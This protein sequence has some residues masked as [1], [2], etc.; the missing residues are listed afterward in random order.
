MAEKKGCWKKEMLHMWECEH[1]R[2]PNVLG[3]FGNLVTLKKLLYRNSP[4]RRDGSPS[5]MAKR[6][7]WEKVQ[8]GDCSDKSCQ[9]TQQASNFEW[10]LRPSFTESTQVLTWLLIRQSFNILLEEIMLQCL[11]FLSTGR[12][13]LAGY[14][15][16]NEL[17]RTKL[18][19]WFNNHGPEWAGVI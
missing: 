7:S 13:N 1:V 12:T 5:F 4:T 3:H 19:L 8:L 9:K 2:I 11:T 17:K 14:K 6:I 16:N 18:S 15:K 10:L